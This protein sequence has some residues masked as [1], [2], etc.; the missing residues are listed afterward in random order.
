LLE[1]KAA[2]FEAMRFN[3]IGSTNDEVS[4]CVAWR[5]AGVSRYQDLFDKELV[6]GASGPAG[7]TNQFPKIANA[8]LHTRFK[9]V[10]GYPGGND[11]DLAMERGEVQGRCGWSWTSVKGTHQAWLD[12]NDIRILFQMG[13]SKHPDLPDVPLITDLAKTEED[14]AVFKIIF[15]RQVMAWPFTAP[16]G[17][18]AERVAALR[19]GFMETMRDKSFLGEASKANFEIR[20]VSGE[21]VQKLV[22]E[23]YE[24]PSAIV[25]KTIQLLQ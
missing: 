19:K 14:R 7:D 22:R 15:A 13:L 18:P 9:I 8:V 12:R 2:Q 21:D 25:Q 17:V 10:T 6:V 3:W 4:V 11:I 5:T 20:P 23:V 24:T 1:S 16:P